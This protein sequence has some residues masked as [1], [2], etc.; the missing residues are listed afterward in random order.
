MN[1]S[2]CEFGII[3]TCSESNFVKQ[4]ACPYF[5][6][7]NTKPGEKCIYYNLEEPHQC[8]CF[9]LYCEKIGVKSDAGKERSIYWN[10]NRKEGS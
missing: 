7:R 8:D 9:E 4:T 5:L 2:L 3:N 1:E 6:A 10:V